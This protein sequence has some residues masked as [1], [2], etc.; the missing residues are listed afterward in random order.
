M[1]FPA[2]VHLPNSP[3]GALSHNQLDTRRLNI[4]L[5]KPHCFLSSEQRRAIRP[6]TDNEFSAAVPYAKPPSIGAYI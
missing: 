4:A 1:A 5:V 3:K 6:T 2:A